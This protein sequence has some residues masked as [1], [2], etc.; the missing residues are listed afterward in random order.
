MLESIPVTFKFDMPS[1]QERDLDGHRR[2][3]CDVFNKLQRRSKVRFAAVSSAK[4]NDPVFCVPRPR[5]TQTSNPASR[6]VSVYLGRDDRLAPAREAVRS[7][8]V[9][10]STKQL[11]RCLGKST[12]IKAIREDGHGIDCKG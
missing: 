7:A 9:W 10:L 5:A 4:K 3:F 12:R 2:K 11:I 1:M 6:N 8:A